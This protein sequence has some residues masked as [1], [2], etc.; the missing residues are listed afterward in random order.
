MLRYQYCST[1]V[2][3]IQFG[4]LSEDYSLRSEAFLT[5]NY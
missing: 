4:S 5:Y 3:G 2:R 1:T